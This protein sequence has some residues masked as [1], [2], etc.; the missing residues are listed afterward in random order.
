MIGTASEHHVIYQYNLHGAK[1]HYLGLI[2]TESVRGLSST[3]SCTSLTLPQPYFQPNPA[4]P[5]PFTINSNLGDPS[6]PADLTSAWALTISQSE[7]I[8]VFGAGLYS[9]FVDYTQECLDTWSCQTQIVNVES[10]GN[11][12]I[13][14]FQLSTVA[15]TNQLSVDGVGVISQADNRNGFASTATVWTL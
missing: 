5:E 9:F 6:F 7:N 8:F 4:V 1:N 3:V 10:A 15:T 13:A 12:N 14:I 11:T 2:Q